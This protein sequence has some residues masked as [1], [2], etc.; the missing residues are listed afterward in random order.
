MISQQDVAS[1]TVLVTKL[2]HDCAAEAFDKAV[3]MFCQ[4][5]RFE[6]EPERIIIKINL[7]EYRLA[8]SGAT[9]DPALLRSL[10]VVLRS[11]FPEASIS[12]AENDATGMEAVSA[13]RYMRIS[14]VA[15]EMDVDLLSFASDDWQTVAIPEGKL[16][17][18]IELPASLGESTLY[19][20]FTKMKINSAS[21]V[22][23]CLKNNYALLRPKNK[24]QFHGVLSQAIYDINLAVQKLRM[25]LLGLVDGCIGMETIG[26]PAF[27]RPK[28]CNLLIAG[29]DSVSI[30]ACES[31]IIGFRPRSVPHI[32]LCAKLGIGSMAYDLR[33]DIEGRLYRD[34]RFKFEAFQYWL[35]NLVKKKV[36]LGA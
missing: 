26:G 29:T 31:R 3:A 4:P 11:R 20:N 9:T 15:E 35:R 13:F 23:G 19:V 33:S 22:T 5:D 34:H 25:P 30:D 24:S 7:C 1:N 2:D 12:I 32:A 18:S 6:R 28:R 17:Q 8:A 10:I 21:K 16:W 27:G 36:G 14:D